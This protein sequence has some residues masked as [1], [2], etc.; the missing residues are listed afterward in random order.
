MADPR[1]RRRQPYLKFDRAFDAARIPDCLHEDALKFQP[2]VLG[3]IGITDETALLFVIAA[4]L[5][6][7]C[8]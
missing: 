5:R 2:P 8:N 4:K 7:K 6:G 1:L 3:F